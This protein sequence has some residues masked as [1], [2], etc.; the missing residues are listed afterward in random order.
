MKH[1]TDT[2][3]DKL[4]RLAK[5]LG[6][7]EPRSSDEEID[8]FPKAARVLDKCRASLL[9]LH[10]EYQFGCPFDQSFF[11]E[12][13]ITQEDFKDIVA[14]GATDEEVG[15]WLRRNAHPHVH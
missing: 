15:E 8:G 13:G 1:S 3:T 12:N 9:G 4:R 11:Q 5:D 10:G 6:Q 7:E 14:T 2:K